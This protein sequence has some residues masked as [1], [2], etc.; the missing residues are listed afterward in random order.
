LYCQDNQVENINGLKSFKFLDTL[1]L[2]NNKL[3]DLDK[4]LRQISKFAFM[5]QL[6][7]FGNPLAEEPDYR[8][9][10]IFLMP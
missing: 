10:F 3:R 1:L 4:F 5:K 9:K 8:L 6:D 2:G 7:L